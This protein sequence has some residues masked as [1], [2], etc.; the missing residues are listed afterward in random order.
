MDREK[1]RKLVG[2]S[3]LGFKD[4]EGFK[5]QLA[6]AIAAAVARAVEDRGAEGAIERYTMID[7]LAD[8]LHKDTLRV[9][10]APG[11]EIELRFTDLP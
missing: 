1:M 2:E 3:R 7:M 11:K 10:L 6:A 9:T 8:A 5:K 4:I